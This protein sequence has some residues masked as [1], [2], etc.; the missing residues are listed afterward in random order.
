MLQHGEKMFRDHDVLFV[1]S[2]KHVVGLAGIIWGI[3]TLILAS[4]F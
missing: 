1:L 2:S 4:V 3:F